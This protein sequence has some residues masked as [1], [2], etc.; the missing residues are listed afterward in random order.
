[1]YFTKIRSFALIGNHCHVEY[2]VFTYELIRRLPGRWPNGGLSEG[3]G[4]EGTGVCLGDGQTE[5]EGVPSKGER[6]ALF[7]VCLHT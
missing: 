3:Y 1:M 4:H 7:G 2:L 6:S 5:A